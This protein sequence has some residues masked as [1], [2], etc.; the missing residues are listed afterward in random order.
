MEEYDAAFSEI[1]D[2]EK[3]YQSDAAYRARTNSET[4]Q[5][6]SDNI[7]KN[8]SVK[9][10]SPLLK[11]IMP[12]FLKMHPMGPHHEWRPA[13]VY[14]TMLRPIAG[15]TARGFLFYQGCS[16]DTH[17]KTYAHLMEVLIR[18]WRKDWKEELPFLFVQLAPFGEWNA[19]TGKNYPILRAQQQYAADHIPNCHMASI[20][21]AGSRYD[22]HPKTKRQP[23]ERLAALALHYVYQDPETTVFEAPRIRKVQR[24]GDRLIV[25]FDYAPEGLELVP[26]DSEFSGLDFLFRVWADRKAVKFHAEIEE[27]TV[28]LSS[29]KIQEAKEV[30][31]SFANRP[32]CIVNLKAKNGFPARPYPKRKVV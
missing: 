21:D 31:L 12:I 30:Y 25:K 5:K 23:G 24:D 19:S 16:D 13:G 10:A 4:G 8:E 7:M 22:I 17:A 28:I 20:M 11:V 32:Y 1:K 9:P 18:R 2:L 29:P 27:D 26:N 6:T 3:Y 15:F 14:Y